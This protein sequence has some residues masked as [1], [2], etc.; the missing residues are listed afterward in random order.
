MYA[1]LLALSSLLFLLDPV[2]ASSGGLILNNRVNDA[3]RI[4]SNLLWPYPLN[5]TLV[6]CCNTS[7]CKASVGQ[8]QWCRSGVLCLHR[9]CYTVPNFPCTTDDVCNEASHTCTKRVCTNGGQCD[10][11]IY[12]NG[13]ERCISGKCY[14]A[15][16]GHCYGG[17]CNETTHACSYPTLFGNWLSYFGIDHDRVPQKK[18]ASKS[19]PRVQHWNSSN[20]SAPHHHHPT[21]SNNDNTNWT[22]WL[23]VG[24]S[25]VV[26]F[27]LVFLMIALVQRNW[28]PVPVNGATWAY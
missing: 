23:L 25:V 26:F 22:V 15:I 8:G 10:D 14:P 19:L 2:Q 21:Q 1:L 6:P 7:M 9:Q 18:I 11:G 4:Q 17:I 12:C 27:V 13:Q 5:N 16:I 24:I 3:V 28:V 20:S